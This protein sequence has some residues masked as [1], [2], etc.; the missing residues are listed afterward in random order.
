M[1]D[2]ITPEFADFEAAMDA[3]I[4]GP[5]AFERE[6]IE[7]GNQHYAPSDTDPATLNA[8][9]GSALAYVFSQQAHEDDED[10][11]QDHG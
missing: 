7:W 6:V 8:V 2:T 1:I 3:A 5:N 10:D 11:E 4:N 9:G